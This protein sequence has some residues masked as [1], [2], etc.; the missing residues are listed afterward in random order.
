[1]FSEV[2]DTVI[3]RA[4][5]PDRKQ[6]IIAW[7]NLTISEMQG[8]TNYFSKN[9]VEDAISVTVAPFIW[10]RPERMQKLRTARYTN[11]VFPRFLMP[12][13]AQFQ[14]NDYYY[15]GSTYFVFSGVSIGEFIN[16]AYYQFRKRLKYFEPGV[17]PAT[18]DFQTETWTYYNLLTLGAAPYNL[19]YTLSENQ[20]TAQDLVSN[21]LLKDWY[22]LVTEGVLA[23]V[24]KGGN[25]ET[26]AAT[27][28]SFFERT[29]N[30]TFLGSEIH[31]TLG[32]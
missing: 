22:D 9:L 18:Y 3:S 11:G 29:Y 8:K 20:Q 31:E 21:W 5:R 23:K 25:D 19:D 15:A 6:D 32:A 26:R 10:T 24:Y 7:L 13:R 16:V 27:H 30:S 1:M 12:G 4:L 17:R 2:V 14:Q 28:F